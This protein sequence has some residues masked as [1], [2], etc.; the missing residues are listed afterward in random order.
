MIVLLFLLWIIFNGK[1]TLEIAVFGAV[2]TALIFA[3]MVAF[4][5]YSWRKEMMVYR[6]IPLGLKYLFVLIWEI[7]KAN[8]VMLGIVV[9][10]KHELEPTIVK[11]QPELQSELA[12]VILANS[13]TLTPG[14]YTVGIDDRELRV[15]CLDKDFSIEIESSVFVKQL[16]R[17]EHV[18]YAKKADKEV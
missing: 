8:A 10:D 6:L 16:Q 3:F 1:L 13:I 9:T 2:F 5:D 15:H 7:I 17:M 11:F 14:T 4:M 18:V 12:R